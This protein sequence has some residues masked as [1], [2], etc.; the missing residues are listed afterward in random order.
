MNN[1]NKL[2]LY[3]HFFTNTEKT[4]F[5]NNE[6]TISTFCY[7]SGVEAVR[8]IIGKGEFIW[9]PFLGQQLWDWNIDG[10]S[11]KFSGFV[12]EPSY[13]KTF[14]ENYGAFLIHCGITGMGNPQ[15]EDSH[16]HHGEL[17][18]A[19]F[20]EA[21]I[22]F[23]FENKEY[24]I[25]LGGTYNRKVPFKE[26]YMFSVVLGINS[27]GL[28]VTSNIDIRNCSHVPL[29][30]MYLSHI[31]FDFH[32]ALSLEYPT[33]QFDSS[34][35]RIIG[36][37]VYKQKPS[38]LL[39]LDEEHEYDPEVVAVLQHKGEEKQFTSKLHK[40]NGN[41]YWV[42]QDTK[43]LDHTVLW[44]THTKDRGACGFALPAT[45]G[46]QGKTAESDYGNMKTLS[47]N[48]DVSLQFSF[49]VSY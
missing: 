29:D 38:L 37:D 22:A 30:Y 3:S 2:H 20:Q 46:P 12:Q 28:S 25:S 33:Y 47:Y 5:S 31:N 6:V 14:L 44:M 9:L 19:I 8:I 41:T 27:N 17:P 35:L 43:I 15:V 26:D 4:L 48:E 1:K 24:P 21:W 32:D 42:T 13:N 39:T 18:V 40:K 16:L 49:G 10:K 36:N 45:A 34:H 23:D 7:Q 11:Q